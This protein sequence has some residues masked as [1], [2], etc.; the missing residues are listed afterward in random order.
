MKW[1]IDEQQL[2]IEGYG[3]HDDDEIEEEEDDN[4]D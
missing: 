2:N 1:Y 3:G 4:S